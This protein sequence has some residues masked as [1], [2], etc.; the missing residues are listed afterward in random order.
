MKTL[1]FYIV[2]AYILA[3]YEIPTVVSIHYTRGRLNP[4]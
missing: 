3:K 1:D 2:G 4:E